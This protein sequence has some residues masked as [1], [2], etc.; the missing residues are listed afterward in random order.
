M[1]Y[2]LSLSLS[3]SS[4]L[5]VQHNRVNNGLVV[6]LYQNDITIGSRVLAAYT[7]DVPTLLES[8]ENILFVTTARL[9]SKA[10]RCIYEQ[11]DLH[12]N[13]HIRVE[14]ISNGDCLYDSSYLGI[15]ACNKALCCGTTE[16]SFI[17]FVLTHCALWKKFEHNVDYDSEYMYRKYLHLGIKPTTF[18]AIIDHQGSMLWHALYGDALPGNLGINTYHKIEFSSDVP[19]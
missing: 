9:L 15:T 5:S 7:E 13:L 6:Y 14:S 18:D 16:K 1:P 11:L 4:T 8:I 3:R 2:N 10:S 19:F 17:S 12:Q